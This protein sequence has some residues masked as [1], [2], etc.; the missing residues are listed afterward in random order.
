MAKVQ[1]NIFVRGLTGA[2]GDQ[3]VIRKSRS[4]RTIVANMP[5]FDEERE[6]TDSQKKQQELFRKATNYAKFAQNQ[7]VYRQKAAGTAVTAYNLA[8]ADYF[9]KPEILDI[10]ISR[11]NGQAGEKI[12]IRAKDNFM[13]V[14]ARLVIRPNSEDYDALDGGEAVQSEMDGLLW[15]FTTT[16]AIALAPGMQLDAFAYDLPGNLGKDSLVLF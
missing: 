10:D 1:N 8:V 5:T 4:G 2:V 11:W 15:E 13:V 9:G 3:F 6:F 14:R 12:Y 7:P 16:Q